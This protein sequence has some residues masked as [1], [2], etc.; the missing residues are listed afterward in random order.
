MPTWPPAPGRRTITIQLQPDQIQH[1]DDQAA[2]IGCTRAATC[3]RLIVQDRDRPEHRTPVDDTVL[4]GTRTVTFELT[5]ELIAYLDKQAAIND[6]S[7]AAVV[8]HLIN[9]DIRRQGPVLA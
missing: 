7:R 9:A 8:R 4:P 3:R 5:V 6:T 1:L 2:Y